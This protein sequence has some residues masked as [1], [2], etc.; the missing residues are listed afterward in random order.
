MSY[1]VCHVSYVISVECVAPIF[2][3][4]SVYTQIDPPS[5]TG[6]NS[7]GN[8][9][10]S[11]PCMPAESP[12]HPDTTPMYCLPSIMNVVGGARMPEGVGAS[13]SS[14]PLDALSA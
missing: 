6:G 12:P 2:P 3:Y 1:V 10:L 14:L 7:P 4:S 8:P 13:Q 5:G 9:R 11:V